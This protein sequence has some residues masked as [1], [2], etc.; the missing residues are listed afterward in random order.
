MGDK[1]AAEVPKAPK[2]AAESA[3]KTDQKNV[4]FD[5]NASNAKPETPNPAK[6]ETPNPAKQ[7][8]PNPAKQETPNPANQETP[9]P[10]KTETPES[11]QNPVK[12]EIVEPAA[13]PETEQKSDAVPAPRR[14]EKD[15]AHFNPN[16]EPANR[17]EPADRT[18]SAPVIDRHPGLPEHAGDVLIN[19]EKIAAMSESERAQ[20]DQVMAKVAD[21]NGRGLDTPP[22]RDPNAR[23]DGDKDNPPDPARDPNLKLNYPE[24]D[25]ALNGEVS[26]GVISKGQLVDRYGDGSGTYVAPAGTDFG[27]RS[28]PPEAQAGEY[29]VMRATEDIPTKQ[30][31]CTPYFGQEGLGVQHKLPT[32]VDSLVVGGKLEEL[33]NRKELL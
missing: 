14:P 20:F 12:Q 7:E 25:G 3:P 19:R 9:N 8:T 23:P 26:P 15:N 16:P 1:T 31:V 30:S 27:A 6:Q 2:P 4:D 22:P 10:A 18:E 21:E 5:P 11:K 29:K 28:M 33:Y 17:I 24:P 32:S 13:K